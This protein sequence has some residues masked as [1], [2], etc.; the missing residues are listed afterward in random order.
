MAVAVGVERTDLYKRSDTT[1]ANGVREAYLYAKPVKVLTT[2]LS[3]STYSCIYEHEGVPY[4]VHDDG[5]AST[6]GEERDDDLVELTKPTAIVPWEWEEI[7]V[8]NWFR[9]KG[10]S[11]ACPCGPVDESDGTISIH[12]EWL[13]MH[14]LLADYEHSEHHC[15]PFSVCGKVK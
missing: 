13:N 12:Y 9:R 4:F 10:S 8:K 3:K 14:E 7:P 15:G 6:S 2:S 5:R 1:V 11:F